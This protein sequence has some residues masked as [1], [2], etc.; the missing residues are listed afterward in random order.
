MQRFGSGPSAPLSSGMRP[1]RALEESR[2]SVNF[3]SV[4][5][6]R[7][8]NTR[9][10][11]TQRTREAQARR[12][13]TLGRTQ[14]LQL[15]TRKSAATAPSVIHTKDRISTLCLHI[16]LAL[17]A[18]WTSELEPILWSTIPLGDSA[19]PEVTKTETSARSQSRRQSIAPEMPPNSSPRTAQTRWTCCHPASSSHWSPERRS[20]KG[21]MPTPPATSRRFRGGEALFW[22]M[23]LP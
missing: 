1:Q 20:M 22:A 21:E 8:S 3:R 16:S 10:R 13:W 12:L 7:T 9:S 5:A 11:G 23:G 15:C 4:T 18:A 2:W 14:V 17:A 19:S 6:R